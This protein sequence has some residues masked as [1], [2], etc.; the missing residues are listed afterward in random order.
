MDKYDNE[1]IVLALIIIII[2]LITVLTCV[3]D[4]CNKAYSNGLEEG[5]TQHNISAYTHALVSSS[6]S[7]E[8]NYNAGY[9]KG[10]EKYKTFGVDVSKS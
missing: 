8:G 9:I 4:E 3:G 5:F 6:I 10:F 2:S 1:I 7:I